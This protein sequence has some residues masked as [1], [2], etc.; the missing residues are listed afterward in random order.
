[1][2]SE[3]VFHEFE[4]HT[5]RSFHVYATPGKE[6]QIISRDGGGN[7]VYMKTFVLNEVAEYD[8]YNLKYLGVIKSI[9][10]KNVIIQPNFDSKTKRLGFKEFAWRNHDFDLARVSQENFKTSSYI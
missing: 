9:T 3:V 5:N 7:V 4:W 8:S 10:A 6:I 1:M 2:K